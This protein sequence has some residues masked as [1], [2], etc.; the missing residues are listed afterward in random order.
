MAK[1]LCAAPIGVKD[2]IMTKGEVTTCGSKMLE[3]YVPEYSATCFLN[4]E[5]A[6]GLMIGKN[7]MDEF[8]MG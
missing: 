8:A 3:G 1:S 6:G 7:A 5:K 4:L 2:I